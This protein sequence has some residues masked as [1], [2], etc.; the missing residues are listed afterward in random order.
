M[1]Q[2]DDPCPSSSDIEFESS[3][4]SDNDD[5]DDD[6]EWLFLAPASPCVAAT[7]QDDHAV[8]WTGILRDVRDPVVGMWSALAARPVAC[9]A[10]CAYLRRPL[11]GKPHKGTGNVRNL[12]LD[13][14][15]ALQPLYKFPSPLPVSVWD[16]DA[17]DLATL[18]TNLASAQRKQRARLYG[19]NC[20][21]AI[22]HMFDGWPIPDH[23]Y[24]PVSARAVGPQTMYLM[25]VSKAPQEIVALFAVHFG[26]DGSEWSR[27]VA[28]IHFYKHAPD[29]ASDIDA[30]AIGPGSR[31]YADL[32]P[33]LLRGVFACWNPGLSHRIGDRQRGPP[34]AIIDAIARRLLS[35]HPVRLPP[36]VY[37]A[38]WPA[39]DV[40]R[41]HKDWQPDKQE[42]AMVWLTEAQLAVASGTIAAYEAAQIVGTN[43]PRY[44]RT[45]PLGTKSLRGCRPQSGV[46]ML[47]SDGTGPLSLLQMAQVRIVKSTWRV[48]LVDLPDDVAAP[49]AVAIWQR[50]CT[51]QRAKDGTV[52]DAARLLDVARYWGVQLTEAQEGRPEWLC[53]DLMPMAL[54]RSASL[55][56]GRAV[57]VAWEATDRPPFPSGEE[58]DRRFRIGMDVDHDGRHQFARATPT[59][60][61][62]H[63]ESAFATIYGRPPV[64]GDGPLVQKATDLAVRANALGAPPEGVGGVC[65]SH[66][67]IIALGV[68]RGGLDVGA[69]VLS[70]PYTATD[71]F[72]GIK[73]QRPEPSVCLF[74]RYRPRRGVDGSDAN[75]DD[76]DDA[77]D[78][79][80]SP[81]PFWSTPEFL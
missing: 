63:V 72:N 37:A 7:K 9:E 66:Q 60:M 34:D 59:E 52:D 22:G 71:V 61:C 51:A 13:L 17:D 18:L 27:L 44:G 10:A 1:H 28:K 43:A 14:A 50:V 15:R 67:A 31:S 77:E 35:T 74:R 68:V 62:T 30:D 48:P 8:D 23:L 76:E 79:S 16:L 19:S 75:T 65:A 81:T 4:S 53:Q 46:G 42:I 11:D 12:A 25:V 2:D 70:D 78:S 57:P 39:S 20:A 41:K 58:K 45:D 40:A 55:S 69:C 3:D 33:T 64:L 29:R 21:I 26:P 32:I 56:G 6:D 80:D 24:Q 54:A 49:L 36:Q 47:R 73:T 5:D 38:L